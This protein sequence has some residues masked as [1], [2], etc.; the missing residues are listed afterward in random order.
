[1]EPREKAPT[2][3]PTTPLETER[4]RL[5]PWTDA[6]VPEILKICQD[7]AV[8]RWTTVPSPYLL[9][10]AE[11]YVREYA[12][13]GFATG[14]E[15]TFGIFVKETGEVAGAIGLMDL[16]GNPVVKTG[17]IGFWANPQTRGRGYLTEAVREVVRWGFE[18]LAVRRIIWQAYDG[19]A[20]SRRVAEKAG[21]TIVGR[22]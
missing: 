2:P 20:A 13:K 19:N 5:R 4:L 1:M 10:D 17:E 22:Q 3:L 8:Q 14:D 21:F 11:W 15:A 16:T 7:P 9:N 18:E 12:P 6:D